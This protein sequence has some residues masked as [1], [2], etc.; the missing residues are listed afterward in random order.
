MARRR[1]ERNILAASGLWLASGVAL[2]APSAA[3]PVPVPQPVPIAAS[4]QV[5]FHC[6][7]VA[8]LPRARVEAVFHTDWNLSDYSGRPAAQQTLLEARAVFTIAPVVAQSAEL[9]AEIVLQ[10]YSAVAHSGAEQVG[11]ALALKA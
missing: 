1:G 5:V 2:G 9:S 3:G 11:Y 6:A 8:K 7:P 4:R 10:E